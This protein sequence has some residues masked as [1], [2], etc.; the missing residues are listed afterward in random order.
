MLPGTSQST[1]GW[2]GS[3]QGF[4]TIFGG[5][6]GGR[7]IDAGWEKPVLVVGAILGPLGMFMTS[8]STEFYQIFLAQGVCTGIGSSLLFLG[9][10]TV[11]P[12]YFKKKRSFALGCCS[13]GSS[14]GG[15]VYP[16]M[17]HRL[18]GS[19]GFA[20]AARS[21]GFVLLASNIFP[22]LVIKSRIPPRRGGQIFELGAFKEPAYVGFL[23]SSVCAFLGAYAVIFFVQSYAVQE[24]IGSELA[25]YITSLLNVGSVPGRIIPNYLAD[26][27][28]PLNVIAPFLGICGILSFC[29]IRV[30]NEADLVVFALLYGLFS[31]VIASLPAPIIASMTKDMSR[32]G[33]RMG[34]NFCIS[35]IGALTSPPI[36]GAL[37]ASG[38]GNYLH[39]QIFSGVLLLASCVFA[40]ASRLAMT[41]FKLKAKA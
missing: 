32:L 31:G 39:V 1:I 12:Q 13:S 15:V 26:K 6:Y 36:A 5:I 27:V 19:I 41:G 10:V 3:F 16:I 37:I 7:L 35:S 2:I 17:T 38:G 24:G 20:W 22:V 14:F 21:L 9:A 25:F 28:G 29:W 23:F 18:I 40:G 11:A 30:S 34:M 8:L 33:T 4:F